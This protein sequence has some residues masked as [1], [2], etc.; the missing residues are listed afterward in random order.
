MAL[1]LSPPSREA[2]DDTTVF[3]LQCVIFVVVSVSAPQLKPFRICVQALG[4]EY[5]SYSDD[6][7][8]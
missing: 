5:P 1:S 3:E 2:S 6:S 8:G 7:G 4:L